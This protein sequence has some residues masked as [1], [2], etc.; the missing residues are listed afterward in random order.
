[1]QLSDLADP[2]ALMSLIGKKT[3]YGRKPGPSAWFYT[4]EWLR[5][6][7]RAED[8][9]RVIAAFAV[10]GVCDEVDAGVWLAEHLDRIP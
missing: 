5:K 4:Q 8:A 9:E 7:G 6:Q 10:V 3:R 2:L 1:M